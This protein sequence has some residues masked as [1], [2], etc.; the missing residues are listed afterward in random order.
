MIRTLMVSAT[1]TSL[2]TTTALAQEQTGVIYAQ[3]NTTAGAA[4][5][6]LQF[7]RYGDAVVWMGRHG[8]G[9]SATDMQQWGT[10]W[11]EGYADTPQGRWVIS[12]ENTF[13]E[14]RPQNGYYSDTITFEIIQTG[15]TAFTL[16]DFYNGGDIPCQVTG[17]Q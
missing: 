2:T 9:S 10:T 4:Q 16:R 1:L 6:A 12:G 11:W 13:I 8:V 7:T 3:C 14:A 17:M 5:L 15:Q